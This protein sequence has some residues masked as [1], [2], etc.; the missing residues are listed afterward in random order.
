MTI[1]NIH[2]KNVYKVRPYGPFDTQQRIN[3]I[4]IHGRVDKVPEQ[5]NANGS[6]PLP[7]HTKR[8]L[9]MELVVI[10]ADARRYGD[11]TRIGRIGIMSYWGIP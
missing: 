6:I 8:R 2:K 11:E 3:T 4:Y 10:L 1:K 5:R 9:R 7:R